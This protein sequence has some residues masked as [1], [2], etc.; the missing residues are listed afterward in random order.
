MGC[1]FILSWR[2]SGG[3]CGRRGSA[4]IDELRGVLKKGGGDEREGES[5]YLIGM[6]GGQNCSRRS[7]TKKKRGKGGV[8]TARSARSAARK[9]RVHDNGGQ[10]MKDA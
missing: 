4:A 3:A 10:Q 9:C 8:L 6:G 2:V 1:C 7:P 5:L